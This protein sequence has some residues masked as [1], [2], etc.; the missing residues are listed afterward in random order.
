MVSDEVRV[1]FTQWRRLAA[2]PLLAATLACNARCADAAEGDAPAT[3]W[4]YR[5]YLLYS[6]QPSPAT[7]GNT[8]ANPQVSIGDLLQRRDAS[9]GAAPHLLL[10]AGFDDRADWESIR[11]GLGLFANLPESGQFHLNLYVRPNAQRPGLR[12]QLQPTGLPLVTSA[13]HQNW[14]VGGFLDYGRGR[15][16]LSNVGFAPQLTLNLRRLL[17]LQGD[18]QASVQYAYWRSDLDDDRPRDRALQAALNWQF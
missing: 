5:D 3:A 15:G 10:S 14:S 12:W 6:A 13:S 7:F 2:C 1:M 18:A 4:R 9:F 16:G 8:A 11:Y 17:H